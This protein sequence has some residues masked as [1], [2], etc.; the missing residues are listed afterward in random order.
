M[1]CDFFT[2]IGQK[3]GQSQSWSE[4]VAPI[5]HCEDVSIK[6][7]KKGAQLSNCCHGWDP[8]LSSS[9]EQVQRFLNGAVCVVCI[10][11]LLFQSGWV[12]IINSE[13]LGWATAGVTCVQLKMPPWTLEYPHPQRYNPAHET[14]YMLACKH[15]LKD[16]YSPG[17]KHKVNNYTLY[18]KNCQESITLL[19]NREQDLPSRPS[20]QSLHSC[21]VQRGQQTDSKGSQPHE[22]LL[23][24]QPVAL[25]VTLHLH[26][27]MICPLLNFQTAMD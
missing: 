3:T 24:S 9:G 27:C 25:S 20:L 2:L 8:F 26:Q 14:L 21:F 7:R 16:T 4:A 22:L 17:Q 5:S 15:I 23:S 10:K 18:S 11:S 1:H 13:M 19:I 12:C 6:I